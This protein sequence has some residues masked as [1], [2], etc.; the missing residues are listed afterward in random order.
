MSPRSRIGHTLAVGALLLGLGSSLPA[1]GEIKWLLSSGNQTGT[2]VTSSSDCSTNCLS[3]VGNTRTFAANS[4]TNSVTASAWSNTLGL[5][6]TTTLPITPSQGTLESA[7]LGLY[8]GGLGV[9]NRDGGSTNGNK[10]DS[11]EWKSPEHAVDNEAR[12]DSVLF[13]F[14]TA[15]DLAKVEIGYIGDVAPITDSDITVLAYTG[16]GVPD[17]GDAKTTYTDPSNVTGLLNKGWECIGHYTNLTT[18]NPVTINTGDVTS[19]YWLIGA[20]IPG[21][22]D[23]GIS[24]ANDAVKVLALYDRNKPP[25]GM[26]EPSA[27]LLL[28]AALAG[29]WAT[30]RRTAAA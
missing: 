23:K 6:S 17:L 20:Y 28:G 1:Y 24:S 12:F 25:T 19:A 22:G 11:N 2:T 26:P 30:R 14:K 10:G 3:S 16:K 7:Y 21:W 15:V 18:G 8:G 4:G 9:K 5:D 29:M 27:L 13:S